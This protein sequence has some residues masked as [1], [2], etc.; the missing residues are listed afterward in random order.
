MLT[1]INGK[2]SDFPVLLEPG[3]CL[4]PN[5]GTGVPVPSAIYCIA[6]Y[7]QRQRDKITVTWAVRL[8]L[9]KCTFTATFWCAI[10]THKVSQTDLLYG[11][12][13]GF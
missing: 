6:N 1:D 8:V 3:T 10:M 2:C 5:P 13:S 11:Y 4:V 12:F 9:W 7:V